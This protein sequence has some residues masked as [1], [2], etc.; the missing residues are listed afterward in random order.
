MSWTCRIVVVALCFLAWAESASGASIPS[1]HPIKVAAVD[2]VPAWGDLDG[3]I[4]RLAQAAEKAAEDG[5][6]YAV[7]PETAVSGYLFSDPAQIA[8]YL[9]TIPGKTT[10]ALLPILART[11]M[12]MSVGI[13]E[14]DVET[15]LAY[16]SAVLLGP[17]GVIGKYRKIGLNPQDQKVF[18]PGNTGVEVFDTPIGRIGLVICYDDTYW[19]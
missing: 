10:A 4:A 18:A 5:V 15:G 13:A 3:N 16:N 6:N 11:G 12:Y 8:P 7:F 17:K 14:R 2:F 1:S 19:Q 9:D